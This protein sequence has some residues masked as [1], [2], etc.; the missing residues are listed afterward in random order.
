MVDGRRCGRPPFTG[1]ATAALCQGG[2][3]PSDARSWTRPTWVRILSNFGQRSPTPT[4]RA[5]SPLGISFHPSCCLHFLPFCGHPDKLLPGIPPETRRSLWLFGATTVGTLTSGT[6]AP[7]APA[8]EKAPYA[9][10]G[11]KLCIAGGVILAI[12]AAPPRAQ[13]LSSLLSGTQSPSRRA[14]VPLAHIWP[15]RDDSLYRVFSAHTRV[16]WRSHLHSGR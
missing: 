9:R 16:D 1:Q 2:P 12:G 14:S 7:A 11:A 3:L 13:M 15:P 6:P 4:P 5:P 10:Y 8:N